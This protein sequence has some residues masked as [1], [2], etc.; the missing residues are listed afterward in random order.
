MGN[1]TLLSYWK[2]PNIPGLD[3]FKGHK[4]HSAAWDAD[5]DYSNKTIAVVGNGSSGV[6][7]IP[8]L[9][10]LPG[11]KLICFQKS[12]NYVYTPWAPATLL[13][14]DDPQ[15]NPPYTEEDKRAFAEDPELHRQYRAR[16]IHSINSG[17][18]RVSSDSTSSLR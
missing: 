14:R 18:R 10:E 1:L 4:T 5:Y 9:A 16:I 12:T 11:N 2:W 17:F 7:I 8:K 6:Q 3:K 15:E 13:G